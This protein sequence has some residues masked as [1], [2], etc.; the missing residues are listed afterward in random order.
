MTH[1]DSPAGVV[2]AKALSA[3]LKSPAQH[4]RQRQQKGQHRPAACECLPSDSSKERQEG[5]GG[6]RVWPGVC[7]VWAS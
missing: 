3:E 4:Q 2:H 6:L 1:H 5:G 7:V